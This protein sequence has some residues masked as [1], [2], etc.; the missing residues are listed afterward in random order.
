MR[1]PILGLVMAVAL[2]AGCAAERQPL[3]GLTPFGGTWTVL[4][5]GGEQIDERIRAPTLQFQVRGILQVVTNCSGLELPVSFGDQRGIAF[6]QPTA[7]GE[8][9]PCDARDR[10]IEAELMAALLEVAAYREGRP[11]DR[12]VFTGPGSE[13]V[14]AQPAANPTRG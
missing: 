14:L 4:S 3:D 8:G 2:L 1:K 11:G 6:G 12:L 5:I 7:T 9:A 10:T 13:I